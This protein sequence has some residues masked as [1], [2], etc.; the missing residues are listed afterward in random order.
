MQETNTKIVPIL[1]KEPS[2]IKLT[3]KIT[4]KPIKHQLGES[5]K[6]PI[7]LRGFDPDFKVAKTTQKE[8]LH[9]P[10]VEEEMKS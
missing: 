9:E 3:H 10:E 6:K 8:R 7:V 5:L 2:P 4:K 1:L